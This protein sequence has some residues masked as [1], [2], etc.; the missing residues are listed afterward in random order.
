M[1]QILFSL[2]DKIFI[3]NGKFLGNT[4]NAYSTINI[5][6][7]IPAGFEQDDTKFIYELAEK[8]HVAV[9]AGSF[10][11]KGGEGYIRLS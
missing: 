4:Y 8:A 7:K 2:N 9:V 11:A 6:A 5:F 1:V 10:F 3:Y